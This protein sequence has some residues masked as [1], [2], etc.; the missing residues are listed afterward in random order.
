MIRKKGR[1]AT[2]KRVNV[3]ILTKRTQTHTEKQTHHK[4][5][6]LCSNDIEAHLANFHP[7]PFQVQ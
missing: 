6:K 7:H 1:N 2:K 4:P 5:H 3:E